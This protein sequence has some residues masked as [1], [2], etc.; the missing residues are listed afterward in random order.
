MTAA[1]NKHLIERYFAAIDANPE[2]ASVLDEFVSPD[3]VDHSPSPGCTA[4]LDGLRAAFRMFATGS[5][6]TH[7]VEDIVAEG[8][9]V[10]ARV[11]GEGVHSGELFGIPPTG[12]T[13]RV[14]GMVIHRIADGKIVERWT[15]VDMLG[16]FVQLGVVQPPG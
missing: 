11:S 6:G 3:F 13:F 15:E 9:R 1:E 16:A 12:R 2:D 4:D 8:D 10:A 7:Q 5:P 14:T